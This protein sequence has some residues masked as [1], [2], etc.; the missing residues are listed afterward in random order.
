VTASN[1]PALLPPV[2]PD[3]AGRLASWLAA[4][5]G[6]RADDP[7]AAEATESGSDGHVVTSLPGAS[8]LAE[9]PLADAWPLRRG[10]R[11]NRLAVVLPA[12]GGA[13]PAVGSGPFAR[14]ALIA[15][16]GV[17]LEGSDTRLGLVPETDQRGSSYCGV[18]WLAFS[19]PVEAA[20]GVLPATDVPHQAV[21]RA[22]EQSDRALRRAVR[23]ATTALEG[24]DLA[25]WRPEVSES[26]SAADA[27]LRAT[28]DR[29]PPGWLPQARLL[30][31]RA[32][33]LWRVLRIASTVPIAVS[34][35]AAMLRDDALRQLSQAVRESLMVGYNAPAQA[36][37][38][39]A[40]EQRVR[41]FG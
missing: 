12:P 15:G 18:R 28:R 10:V 8:S 1:P 6:G 5:I 30:V 4:S 16:S 33:G 41:E 32:L 22:I 11:P 39:G 31:E 7:R 37:L 3:S 24:I 20:V 35:S 25:H 26:G 13:V 34:A 38:R 14:A 29:L 27:T 36:L 9:I 17:L 19:E 21:S 40:V 23:S 2:D